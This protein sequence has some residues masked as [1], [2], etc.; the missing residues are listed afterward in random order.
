[1]KHPLI[2]IFIPTYNRSALLKKTIES[3]LAQDIDLYEI[4]VADDGSN[5]DTSQVV[6]GLKGQ[7]EKIVYLRLEKNTKGKLI[8]S[9]AR[10]IKSRFI[11]RIGDDDLLC[12]NVLSKYAKAALEDKARFVYGDIRL[13]SKDGTVDRIQQYRDYSDK[14]HML[15]QDL[16]HGNCFPFPGS[17][18]DVDLYWRHLVRSS[19]TAFPRTAF[20]VIND[21]AG[22]AIDYLEWILLAGTG[23]R[24]KHVGMTTVHYRVHSAQDSNPMYKNGSEESFVARMMLALHPIREIFPNEDWEGNP[25]LSEARFLLT[26]GKIMGGVFDSYNALACYKR[27]LSFTLLPPKA[28]EEAIIGHVQTA[29]NMT[30]DPLAFPPDTPGSLEQKCDELDLTNAK[31]MIAIY[32]KLGETTKKILSAAK[33]LKEQQDLNAAEKLLEKTIT[34]PATRTAPA[35]RFLSEIYQCQNRSELAYHCAIFAAALGGYA[36]P[37]YN[38]ALELVRPMERADE[39]NRMYRRTLI[40]PVHLMKWRYPDEALFDNDFDLAKKINRQEPKFYLGSAVET[41]G[42]VRSLPPMRVD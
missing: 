38:Y 7:T 13:F 26:L 21:C 9:L 25:V 1:M 36:A 37:Y 34:N 30:G 20:P 39:L 40:Q 11:F 12:P 15:L 24:F 42:P 28:V 5:D 27:V 10:Q 23:H 8:Y 18:I 29:F 4:V 17:M 22:R 16:L 41:L 6:E 32:L 2:S 35:I 33:R 14:P 3:C 31:K 19:Y